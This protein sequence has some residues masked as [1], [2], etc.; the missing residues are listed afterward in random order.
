MKKLISLLLG[1]LLVAVLAVSGSVPALAAEPVDTDCPASLTLQYKY[2]GEYFEG[3]EIKTYRIADVFEDG[4][5]ELCAPFD[6]LPVSIHGITTQTEWKVITSTLAIFTVADELEPTLSA[7]TD[8]EGFVKF[9]NILPGMYLTLSQKVVTESQSTE[10]ESF[11]TVIPSPDEDGNHNYNV[12]AYPKC[13]ARILTPDEI[14]YKA[15]KQWNDTGYT[16]KR[17]E[18]VNI[19]IYK[20]GVLQST[21]KLSAEND[22]CYSWTA[23]DDGGVWQ[24]VERSVPEGY[25]VTVSESGNTL[26][27]TNTYDYGDSDAPQTGDTLV[28][29]P[30]I[31]IMCLAGG[32]VITIAVYRKRTAK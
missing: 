26:I 2:G 25:T 6:S 18:F 28:M 10:F 5:F 17:P 9:E 29:W 4:T 15:V 14:G 11:I 24:A 30:Y 22:W 23:P 21:E 20:D 16:E 1:C 3:L 27:I 12:T 7:L 13:D 19:D 8:E 31:L 32:T